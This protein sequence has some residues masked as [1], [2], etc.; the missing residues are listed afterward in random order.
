MDSIIRFLNNWDQV[1]KWVQ[2]IEVSFGY[3]HTLTLS[4]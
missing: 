2:C 4:I 3:D 1:Y